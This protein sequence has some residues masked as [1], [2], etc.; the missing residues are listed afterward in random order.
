M[1]SRYSII[2]RYFIRQFFIIF[3]FVCFPFWLN[4]AESEP[5]KVPMKEAY[6]DFKVSIGVSL[7]SSEITRTETAYIV[8][9][10][11]ESITSKTELR[12][13]KILNIRPSRTVPF[14]ALDGKTYNMPFKINDTPIVNAL[15]KAKDMRV[16]L[17][18]H[19]LIWHEHFPSWFFYKE[20]DTSKGLV[21]QSTMNA[22]IEWY[23]TSFI[24]TVRKWEKVNA[25]TIQVVGAFHVAS[26]IYTETG[27]LR[28]KEGSL[29]S[30]IYTDNSYVLHAYKIVCSMAKDTEK[31]VYSDSNLHI[32]KKREAV[33]KLVEQIKKSGGKVDEIA[34]ISHLTSDWPNRNEYFDA[35]KA[36]GRK[37]LAVHIA[38]LDIASYDGKN[39]ADCYADFM[40][41]VLDNRSII[42]EVSFRNI[43]QSSEKIYIDT[44]RSPIF[45]ANFSPND[46]YYSIIKAAEKYKK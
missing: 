11:F 26:E 44:M 3:L 32:T 17:R 1:F 21:D 16:L 14:T 43:I 12:A 28:E 2:M 35:I 33:L 42:S 34:V 27:K 4:A 9:T 41:Q 25:R 15:A 37:G 46:S 5:S 20:F 45:D 8:Q 36:F 13:D 6:Q 7:D 23:I 10:N 24:E 30:A 40:K 19:P 38:Q 18:I 22:R 31:I 39:E 29:W